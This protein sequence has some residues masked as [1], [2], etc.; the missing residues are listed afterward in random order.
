[1]YYLNLIKW[2]VIRKTPD[3]KEIIFLNGGLKLLEK[4]SLFC[5]AY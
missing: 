3:A 1:M 5:L 2:L 4:E